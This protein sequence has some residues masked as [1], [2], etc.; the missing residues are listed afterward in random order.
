MS[1]V[2]GIRSRTSTLRFLEYTKDTVFSLKSI[3]FSAPKNT[4]KDTPGLGNYFSLTKKV[5]TENPFFE[6][7]S[8]FPV[9]LLVPKNNFQLKK[10]PF[11]KPK[12]AMKAGGYLLTK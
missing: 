3:T 8:I 10:L 11:L 9:S 1:H 6:K 2:F 12:S 7:K 5:E 4:L